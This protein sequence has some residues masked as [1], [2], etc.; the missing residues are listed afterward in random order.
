MQKQQILRELDETGL[1]AGVQINQA[2]LANDRAKYLLTLLQLAFE[3]A[4]RKDPDPDTLARERR[5]LQLEDSFL[6]TVIPN[7]RK[8]A[9]GTYH[10]AGAKRTLMLLEKCCREML[11]PVTSANAPESRELEGRL[12]KIL[13][14]SQQV[15]EDALPEAWLQDLTRG[16]QGS[17]DSLHLYV[18]DTHKV[19]NR[20]QRDLS[21]TRVDGVP[22][23]GILESDRPLIRAFMAGVKETAHL[24]L[25]HP[26]LGTTASRY[27]GRL[28]IQNDVGLTDS[29][30]IVIGL[31]DSEV[32]VTY[33]DVHDRRVSFFRSMLKDLDPDWHELSTHSSAKLEEGD[34][35]YLLRG[36]IRLSGDKART[37]ALHHLGSRLVFLI[38]WNKA[39][40]R[41]RNFLPNK[42][43]VRVLQTSAREN[44]GHMAFLKLGHAEL[45]YQA[46]DVAAAEHLR[47]GEPFHAAVGTKAAEQCFVEILRT[48]YSGISNNDSVQVVR[49]RIV[50]VITSALHQKRRGALIDCRMQTALLVEAALTLHHSMQ[51]LRR[52]NDSWEYVVRSQKRIERW[53]NEA[54]DILNQ[55]RRKEGLRPSHMPVRELSGALDDA[56]DAIERSAYF[57][58]RLKSVS[59]EPA[60]LCSLGELTAILVRCAQECYKAIATVAEGPAQRT[61]DDLPAFFESVGRLDS[62]TK[63]KDAQER[64]Y[65]EEIFELPESPG[66]IQRWREIGL[67]ISQAVDHLGRAAFLLYDS[68]FRPGQI[69]A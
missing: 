42:S 2:L 62:M 36:T 41:L 32:E 44:V 67:E 40:K 14:A 60:V 19:I 51:W 53:E 48:C 4:R 57:L 27:A 64:D 65:L 29:H 18:M 56:L 35:Y 10:I 59:F 25:D 6:D 46:L 52:G 61:E 54:D 8:G 1:L 26:G 38:D 15:D 12:E 39:R 37:T 50:S 16:T 5:R 3:Q 23:V 66:H 9:N 28:V 20:V 7:A 33:T 21:E 45:V 34:K 22:A 47:Y 13:T 30:V 24:K 43:A 58:S 55:L 49:D 63:L 11:E 69:G 68:I 31:T 17:K